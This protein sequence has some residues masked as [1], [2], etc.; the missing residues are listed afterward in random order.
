MPDICHSVGTTFRETLPLKDS[1]DRT[2]GFGRIPQDE[3]KTKAQGRARDV[4][5]VSI[6]TAGCG[7]L[8]FQMNLTKI[9]G[10][11]PE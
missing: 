10:S 4:D 7:L 9:R 5:E 1:W 3:S 8:T 6:V 11:N 2:L